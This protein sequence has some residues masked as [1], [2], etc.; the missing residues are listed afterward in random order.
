MKRILVGLGVVA[1]AWAA[2]ISQ[3]QA[4]NFPTKSVRWIVPYPAGG[5][6]D[7]LARTVSQAMAQD[8]GQPV[9]IDNRAGGN[10]AI[11]AAETIRSGP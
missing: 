1:V 3:A 10:T 7:F 5:G 6:S 8:L 2:P 9:V 11:A 4:Q